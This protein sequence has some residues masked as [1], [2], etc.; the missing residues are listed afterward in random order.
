MEKL[1]GNPIRINVWF[2]L[3]VGTILTLIAFYQAANF[4]GEKSL[5]KERYINGTTVNVTIQEVCLIQIHFLISM[6]SF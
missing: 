3:G 6:C 5:Q 4:N 1:E 2:I